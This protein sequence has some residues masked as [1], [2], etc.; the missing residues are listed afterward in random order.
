[1]RQVARELG[2]RYVLEGSGRMSGNRARINA[3]LIDT[4][5]GGHL[6]AERYDTVVDDLFDVRG[7]VIHPHHHTR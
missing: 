6:W 7:D 5:S 3:Q 4:L 2:V 1:M